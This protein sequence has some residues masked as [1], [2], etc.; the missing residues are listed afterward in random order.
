M[1]RMN[2]VLSPWETI[3]ETGYRFWR[4]P[5]L[6]GTAMSNYV[7]VS[8][9]PLFYACTEL[10]WVLWTGAGKRT[11]TMPKHINQGMQRY[12]SFPLRKREQTSCHEFVG[13][14]AD[15]T[16]Y[17]GYGYKWQT[18]QELSKEAA[19]TLPTGS[20]VI[21]SHTPGRIRHAAVSIGH[22]LFLAVQGTGGRLAVMDMKQMQ[23]CYPGCAVLQA[24]A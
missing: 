15:I 21:L 16:Y 20:Y 14:I 1:P 4:Y 24:W 19:H 7:D 17:P 6:M 3:D 22:G 23:H 13:M 10:E 5:L 18:A 8:W 12:L 9:M 11:L 2:I